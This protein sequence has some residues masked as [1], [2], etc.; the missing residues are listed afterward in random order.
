M[1][2]GAHPFRIVTLEDG[3]VAV[4]K[5][6]PRKPQLLELI[7]I[8]YDAALAQDY[9]DRENSRSAEP[10]AAQQRSERA[11]ATSDLSPRQSAVME[12]LRSKMDEHKQVAAKAANLAAAAQ[13]PLGSL[14]SVLQSLEKRQL[15]STLRSGS[16]GSPAVYQVL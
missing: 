6:D 10:E 9:A 1:S 14:H 7:A 4:V 8:F 16:A 3:S 11:E 2:T 12:T 5:R 15:I 13:I